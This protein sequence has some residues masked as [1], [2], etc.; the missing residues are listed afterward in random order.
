MTMAGSKRCPVAEQRISKEMPPLPPM[1]RE[2]NPPSD[3]DRTQLY[4]S[5]QMHAYGRECM[6]W[7]R[8]RVAHGVMGHQISC[9]NSSSTCPES[10]KHCRWVEGEC[11]T[12][13][14]H[15]VKA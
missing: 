11:Q 15:G 14:A 1:L 3:G 13:G 4:T 5:D 6:E 7:S 8:L 12:C 2:H 10:G 9:S